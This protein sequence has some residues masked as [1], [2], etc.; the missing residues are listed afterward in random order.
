MLACEKECVPSTYGS[1]VWSTKLVEI[2]LRMRYINLLGL[3]AKKGN[4]PGEILEHARAK[5][6]SEDLSSYSVE[7]L[8]ISTSQTREELRQIQERAVEIRANELQERAEAY[9]AEG[10]LPMGK[11]LKIL[12]EQ[13]QIKG[14]YSSIQ[15]ELKQKKYASLTRLIVPG[16]KY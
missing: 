6:K 9:I 16:E 3:Q 15:R 4:I 8:K 13:E 10:K 7:E 12:I 14:D 2:G 1:F 11:A 5:A